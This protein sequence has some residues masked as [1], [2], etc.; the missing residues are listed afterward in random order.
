MDIGGI[1]DGT[2]NT[3]LM[4]ERKVHVRGSRDFLLSVRIN[5][6][7]V[8]GDNSP[9]HANFIP[10]NVFTLIDS[11]DR[12]FTGTDVESDRT[13]QR[14]HSGMSV[15]TTFSTILPPNSPSVTRGNDTTRF[16]GGPTSNHPGGVNIT[17]SD[18][19][20]RFISNTVDTGDLESSAVESGPSP[21][22]VW[23]RLGSAAGNDSAGL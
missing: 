2:S 21:F 8:I 20:G 23:G 5:A 6:T 18:A 11:S 14:W 1:T 16:L 22:G 10:N 17:M 7:T 3:I 9:L 13:G 19:S 4:S 15:Y 12:S